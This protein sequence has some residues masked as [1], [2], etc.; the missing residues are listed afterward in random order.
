MSDCLPGGSKKPTITVTFDTPQDIV[1]SGWWD[2]ED[3][4][5]RFIYTGEEGTQ[6]VE[7]PTTPDKTGVVVDISS[8]PK[9]PKKVTEIKLVYSG[10]G[11]FYSLTLCKSVGSLV[12][13]PHIRTLDGQH[14]TLLNTGTFSAWHLQGL[15]TSFYSHHELT[16]AS[17]DWQ[18]FVRYSSRGWTRGLLVVDN[19]GGVPRQ[20]LEMTSEDCKWKAPSKEGFW[21]LIEK[22]M[23][24]SP[25]DS[26]TDF[27]LEESRKPKS[28]GQKTFEA[29]FRM[30][31]LH[32]MQT[33]ATA[34][35]RCK[36]GAHIN[37]KVVS[38]RME[39]V[40]FVGGQLGHQH[41]EKLSLSA[42]SKM[43]QEWSV[44]DKSWTDLGGSAAA[45]SFL[46]E[47]DVGHH[48]LGSANFLKTCTA[49][50]K[51]DQDLC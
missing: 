15:E 9:L 38:N 19:F 47:M 42:T 7:V 49:D 44:S 8:Q 24:V 37:L 6:A 3:T 10:S 26:Y 14:Y 30:K 46:K 36:P 23:L 33:V 51:K 27:Q 16:K 45:A 50:E 29:A 39:D 48:V 40:H 20:R 35:A 43:D 34:V 5:A 4:G 22:P 32:G 12:G 28:N 2:Q 1:A 25:S 17:V 13:D 11:G 31:T 41:G 21:E 18:I